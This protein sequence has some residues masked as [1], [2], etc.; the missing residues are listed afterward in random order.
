MAEV[1]SKIYGITA[2]FDIALIAAL[3]TVYAIIVSLMSRM[4]AWV[5][6]K[7]QEIE[8]RKGEAKEKFQAELSSVKDKEPQEIIEKLTEKWEASK[9]ELTK[10]EMTFKRRERLL[11]WGGIIVF[12]G[13]LL[14]ISLILTLVAILTRESSP[15]CSA[16][17][18][19][20][21][22]AASLWAL[23]RI[24]LTLKEAT[25]LAK[26]TSPQEK[27]ELEKLFKEVFGLK[28]PEYEVFFEMD[29]KPVDTLSINKDEEQWSK[30]LVDNR[31]RFAVKDLAVELILP[32]G[33]T[34][35]RRT[36]DT[37][38][39]RSATDD[40]YPCGAELR[41]K[42]QTL[43]PDTRQFIPFLIKGENA[44]KFEMYVWIDSTTHERFEHKLKVRVVKPK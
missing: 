17:F 35:R 8:L 22:V 7:L 18:Y 25:E 19:I 9:A 32:E 37:P 15:L 3:A 24:A 20:G 27:Q 30:L 6:E 42:T 38:Q 1:L 26:E 16:G 23:F 14:V 29:E 12:T 28:K 11:S 13:S 44:G 39:P 36:Q 21:A 4:L 5:R 2:Y 33:F 34:L 41:V 40:P 43:L 10:T 31:S